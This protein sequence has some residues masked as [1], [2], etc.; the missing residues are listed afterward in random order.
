VDPRHDRPLCRPH[1]IRTRSR[2]S[3]RPEPGRPVVTDDPFKRLVEH[4]RIATA[5][6]EATKKLG[7]L[8]Q[9]RVI[10]YRCPDRKRCLLLDVAR[11]P[12]PVGMV[13]HRPGYRLSPTVNA[14]SSSADGRRVNTIDGD[15]RWK[16]HTF[17][18]A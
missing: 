8:A 9:H 10:A 3:P 4:T 1:R 5:A 18:P 7:K 17:S 15:R 13:F 14:A 16:A 12:D 2:R 11:F 6:Y